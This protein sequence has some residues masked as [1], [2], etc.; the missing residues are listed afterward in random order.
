M[1]DCNSRYSEQRR[2][3]LLALKFLHK[4]KNPTPLR[5]KSIRTIQRDLADLRK[6][7]DHPISTL[8]SARL[9]QLRL[10]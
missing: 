1:R 3:Y 8:S 5:R 4:E 7:K 10:F 6:T 2:Q 9:E